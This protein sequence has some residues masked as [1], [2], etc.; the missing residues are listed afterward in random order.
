MLI[1][2]PVTSSVAMSQNAL[3]SMHF[4][5]TFTEPANVTIAERV[6]SLLPFLDEAYELL[7]E[8]TQFTPY[9]GDKIEIK[10]D[11]SFFADKPEKIIGWSGNPIHIKLYPSGNVEQDLYIYFHELSHDFTPLSLSKAWDETKSLTEGLAD[12]GAVFL[13]SSLSGSLRNQSEIFADIFLGILRQY[14]T[15]GSPFQVVKWLEEHPDD[16][17]PSDRLVAGILVAIARRF[18]WQMFTNFFTLGKDGKGESIFGDLLSFNAKMNFFVYLLSLSTGADLTSL[19]RFW[20]FPLDADSDG[21]GVTDAGEIAYGLSAPDFDQD[22][23]NDKEE[24]NLKTNPNNRDTD[25]DGL[26]DGWEIEISTNP[27]E[28]DSDE[29]G[30]NDYDETV[31]FHTNPT[32]KDTDKD[33]W[34]DYAEIS[35]VRWTDE[36]I[37]LLLPIVR[38][39]PLNWWLPNILF[40]TSLLLILIVILKRR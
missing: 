4:K 6:K 40:L 25:N 31:I 14:E 17:H 27:L 18:G 36:N 32:A 35:I 21:D 1:S 37:P 29:D 26:E 5:V 19:F 10:Y 20:R 9:S 12:L 8:W 16:E 3:E 38:L 7:L 24:I 39:M 30:V 13:Y 2:N 11:K 22:K 28:Q 15:S 33:L 23:L 34:S